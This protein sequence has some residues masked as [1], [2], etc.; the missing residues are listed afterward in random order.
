MLFCLLLLSLSLVTIRSLDVEEEIYNIGIEMDMKFLKTAT[1]R[2]FKSR[3]ING[4]LKTG[5]YNLTDV[6]IK[7]YQKTMRLESDYT[8]TNTTQFGQFW[9][10][11]TMKQSRIELINYSGL[12]ANNE[13][14]FPMEIIQT[15]DENYVIMQ[16]S[17]DIECIIKNRTTIMNT[18][19]YEYY[20]TMFLIPNSKQFE[21]IWG[22]RLI[23]IYIANDESKNNT[24][25]FIGFNAFNND[26]VVFGI[27]SDLLHQYL[28]VNDYNNDVID[29]DNVMLPKY[30]N[31]SNTTDQ[32][33]SFNELSLIDNLFS[34]YL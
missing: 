16:N 4:L 22:P 8:V 27:Y 3:Y 10:S 34:N 21:I 31:C 2:N 17:S 26:V 18:T 32:F 12:N 25:Y 30:V 9:Y 15:M 6:N 1:Q 29:E 33:S 14:G 13:S 11:S 19:T 23:D 20:N 24:L 7:F 5:M 28:I